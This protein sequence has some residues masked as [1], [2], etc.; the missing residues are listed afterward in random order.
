MK[1]GEGS[2]AKGRRAEDEGSRRRTRSSASSEPKS[3][4]ELELRRHLKVLEDENIELRRK[5]QEK[6]ALLHLMSSPPRDMPSAPTYPSACSPS[7][8]EA[9]SA[10]AQQTQK[11]H[12]HVLLVEDDHFQCD[13]TKTL[14]EIVERDSMVGLEIHVATSGSRAL[15]MIRAMIRNNGGSVNE[16]SESPSASE[17]SG[18]VAGSSAGSDPK[19]DGGAGGGLG[20]EAASGPPAR[21][22]QSPADMEVPPWVDIVLCD[23]LI[24]ND[25]GWVARALDSSFRSPSP[26]SLPPPPRFSTPSPPSARPPQVRP[27]TEVSRAA[28]RHRPSAHALLSL[29]HA[30]GR[31]LHPRRRRRLPRQTA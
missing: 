30:Y 19:A 6:L 27:A 18:S 17:A 31:A 10:N 11:V 28:R 21:T 4:E 9:Q 23:V 12:A 1:R 3:S 26:P 13:L 22:Q 25:K 7:G 24:G 15:A 5:H 16:L 20:D 2:R 14:A 29:Q 8:T